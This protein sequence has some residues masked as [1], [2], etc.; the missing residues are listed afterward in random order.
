MTGA[1]ITLW[2]SW[3]SGGMDSWGME[4]RIPTGASDSCFRQSVRSSFGALP[5]CC[6]VG[7]GGFFSGVQR[8]GREA[9][10]HQVPS[11]RMNG[12]I[13][14]LLH[15]AI[16]AYRE[17]GCFLCTWTPSLRYL[18]VAYFC[19]TL[20]LWTKKCKFRFLIWKLSDMTSNIRIVEMLVVTDV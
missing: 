6:S 17:T 11:L 15:I 12:F 18:S 8:P 5:A 20:L 1:W 14:V 16:M 10:H 2:I 3:V 9:D 4:V 7:T 19:F 13:P